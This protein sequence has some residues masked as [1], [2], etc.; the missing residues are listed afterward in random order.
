M[1][2]RIPC[3]ELT[4]LGEALPEKWKVVG[5]RFCSDAIFKRLEGHLVFK[6][7]SLQ[8]S[9]NCTDPLKGAVIV[10]NFNLPG[11]DNTR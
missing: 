5:A 8:S 11:I 7:R 10:S 6:L 2:V 9:R 1:S 4:L 3:D